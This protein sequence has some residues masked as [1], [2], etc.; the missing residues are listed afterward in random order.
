MCVL[1]NRVPIAWAVC[2][3]NP[4]HRPKRHPH[5]RA[6]NGKLSLPFA[7]RKSLPGGLVCGLAGPFVIRALARSLQPLVRSCPAA[8]AHMCQ[9]DCDRSQMPIDGLIQSIDTQNTQPLIQERRLLRLQELAWAIPHP[10][11]CCCSITLPRAYP[12]LLHPS[13]SPGP[14]AIDRSRASKQQPAASSSIDVG[15]AACGCR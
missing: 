3:L 5:K 14:A 1:S 11:G 8:G 9:Q 15:D 2:G 13:A 4:T 6:F 10:V 7:E 12:L